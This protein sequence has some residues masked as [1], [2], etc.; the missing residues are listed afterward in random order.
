MAEREAHLS[1]VGDMQFRART[2]S[3]HDLLL[4]AGADIGGQ[5]SGPSPVEMV[6]VALGGCGAMDVISILRKMRQDVT[7]YDVSVVAQ[8]AEEHP[9]VFT[10]ITMT[11]ALAGASLEP[12]NVQ[13]AI[14]LSMTRYCPVFAM[15]SPTVPVRVLYTISDAAGG[16]TSTGDVTS[17]DSVGR[18]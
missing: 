12:D 15:L 10:S 1:L 13:R 17:S 8:R 6:L 18:A 2:G 3:G 9:K 4:D 16:V 7:S 5:N 11:H 14:T